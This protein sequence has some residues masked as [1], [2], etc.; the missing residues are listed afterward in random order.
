M[1]NNQF[2]L[3]GNIC[4]D[5]RLLREATDDQ[6]MKVE[7]III[8]NDVLDKKGKPNSLRVHAYGETAENVYEDLHN[9]DKVALNGYIKRTI[10]NANVKPVVYGTDL[11]IESYELI[12]KRPVRDNNGSG[13]YEEEEE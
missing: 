6:V 7:I 9:G 3:I 13:E 11:I 2:E 4:G 12:K 5:L 8:P 10:L 1:K